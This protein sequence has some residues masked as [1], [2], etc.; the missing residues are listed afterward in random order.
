[1]TSFKT[2]LNAEL[3]HDD[4]QT[5]ILIKPL[6]YQ[7]ECAGM[8]ITVPTGFITDLASVPRLPF[9][10]WMAGGTASRAAVIHDFLYVTKIVTKDVADLVFLEAMKDSGVG[11]VRRRVMY[12]AV[13]LFGGRGTQNG[14]E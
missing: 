5:W 12:W 13:W 2:K 10:Y 3:I 9:A 7:S 14:D 6:I 8:T 11:S 1:M 4:P